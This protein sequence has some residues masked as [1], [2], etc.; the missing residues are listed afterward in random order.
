[1]WPSREATLVES[2][3]LSAL[4]NASYKQK[5]LLPTITVLMLEPLEDY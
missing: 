2:F 3:V 4:L 1:M 5:G